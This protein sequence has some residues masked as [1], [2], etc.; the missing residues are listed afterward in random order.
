M[1]TCVPCIVSAT[2]GSLPNELA[3]FVK[4]MGLACLAGWGRCGIEIED[5]D[6]ELYLATAPEL[7]N[8][9]GEYFVNN[10]KRRMPAVV[11]DK[12]TRLRLWEIMEEHTGVK[13]PV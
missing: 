10:R 13:F 7:A 4:I 5:A 9:T 1:C 2:E 11:H 3:G 12:A 6:G 8:V